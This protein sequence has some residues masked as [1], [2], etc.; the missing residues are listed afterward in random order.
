[1]LSDGNKKVKKIGKN[2]QLSLK[3]RR[4]GGGKKGISQNLI[5]SRI[6][7]NCTGR[8][9]R[10]RGGWRGTSGRENLWRRNA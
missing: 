2:G 4:W 3:Q 6:I 7:E 8:E 9:K 5:S 10:R 1:M